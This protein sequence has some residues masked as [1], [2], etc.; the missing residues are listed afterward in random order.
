MKVVKGA[1]V[2]RKKPLTLLIGQCLAAGFT[3]GLHA[4]TIEV[5]AGA[6][7]DADDGVCSIV[8]AVYNANTN[9]QRFNSAGECEA[10]DTSV[11][12]INLAP[13]VFTLNTPIA[14]TNT[15]DRGLPEITQGLIING[16]GSTITRDN[17]GPDFGI[18]GFANSYGQLTLNSMTISNG[19][20]GSNYS[21]GGGIRIQTT[22]NYN[23]PT[24][25][26]TNSI[27]S[28]NVGRGAIYGNRAEINLTNSTIT[29]NSGNLPGI[30]AYGR[31]NATLTITNSTISGNT[32]SSNFG[33][34]V[35]TNGYLILNNTTV[36]PNNGRGL[37]LYI[38][39]YGG[40]SRT[41]TITGSRIIDNETQGSGGGIF[42][43][44][45]IEITDT[46]IAGNTA[47]YG[48]GIGSNRGGL[49]MSNSRVI[50]N[51]ANNGGGIHFY[52]NGGASNIVD[53]TI[54]GNTA[55]LAG[56]GIRTQSRDLCCD[57]TLGR[58]YVQNS[59]ITNNYAQTG[60]GIK[61]EGP[62]TVVNS[63]L[64]H[65]TATY[66]GG[67][68]YSKTPVS[69]YGGS[70]EA[71]ELDVA[72]STIT[73]NASF[74]RG[75]GVWLDL[76]T[77]SASIRNTIIANGIGNFD[78]ELEAGVLTQNLH[79]LIEDGTCSDGA[80][81]LVTGDPLLG[82]LAFNGSP[83]LSHR[84]LT[85]SLAIDAADSGTCEATDQRGA[86]RIPVVCDIGS[87]EITAPIRVDESAGAGV[88]A[89]D[90]NDGLCSLP[91]AMI[92]ANAD[93][94]ISTSDGEC[95]P[96]VVGAA[97]RIVLPS[98]VTFSLLAPDPT[99]IDNGLPRVTND[100][101]LE[102]NSATVQ[103]GSAD[104]RGGLP[105]FRLLENDGRIGI[106]NL[107]MSGGAGQYIGGAILNSGQLWLTDSTLSGNRALQFGGAI[108][109]QPA[110]I[111]TMAGSTLTQNYAGA[112]S[113]AV[114][115]YGTLSISNS[116]ISSNTAGYLTG[117][118]SSLTGPATLPASASITNST[119]GFNV[120]PYGTYARA[121]G[122]YAPLDLVN[123]LIADGDVGNGSDCVSTSPGLNTNNLVEDGTC[124]A[125]FSTNDPNLSLLAPLADNGGPTM[126]HDLVFAQNDAVDNGDAAACADQQY[127]QRGAPFDRSV[128]GDN[129]GGAVCDIGA[130]EFSDEL[131]P[132]AALVADD[133]VAAANAYDFMVMFSDDSQVN[134]ATVGT[135]D[136]TVTGPG[137]AI[138]ITG[139]VVDVAPDLTVTATYSLTPPGGVWDPS[140]NGTYTVELGTDEV[141]DIFGKPADA[142]LLG[143]FE[144]ALPIPEIDVQ[145]NGISIA[146]GDASPS[147][148][149]GT[150]FG[151]VAV[152]QSLA[153]TFTIRNT[154]TLD[155][156]L[157]GSPL[158]AVTGSDFVV[159]AQPGTS[160]IAPNGSTTFEITFTPTAEVPSSVAVLI[161]NDDADESLYDF[162]IS[163][164]GAPD[165]TAPMLEDATFD[166][167]NVLR[168][169]D[170]VGQL[171]VTDNENNIPGSG[172]YQITAG[173]TGGAF[174]VEDDGSI[175]VAN[176]MA[177]TSDFTLTVEVTDSGSLSD[178]ATVTINVAQ[179]LIFRDDFGS[180][181]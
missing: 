61:N 14:T 10:G 29:N 28:N 62:L 136:V 121:L 90:G 88:V 79:N 12:T 172:A 131:V 156:N 4:A 85:G 170:T 152:G 149:D 72:N 132:M 174:A 93:A 125:T 26:I 176:E 103:R 40:G 22:S 154:G 45:P 138:P 73:D 6:V 50:N 100:M 86:P 164:A 148:D 67:G 101:I 105:S 11:D 49:E 124:S 48:G 155:L 145:G 98:N 34:I 113:G 119:F 52:S 135:S 16:N 133:V 158:V 97:D 23:Q 71:A 76:T 69:T 35:S 175:T 58:I 20:L 77:G 96:G 157:T 59:A 55:T 19:D 5:D 168:T 129:S 13:S 178:T 116:T 169:G 84:P 83:T 130:V 150:D 112:I 27:I 47:N 25:T 1:N 163:G 141:Q 126:T 166:I 31:E 75:D 134:D 17:A 46:L 147:S 70:P 162:V 54:D 91:E 104:I 56:G 30:Y 179:I 36:G 81:D 161:E 87:I 180:G 128:D 24:L 107:T 78:C 137:G 43:N 57:Q 8:E 18:I 117:G 153:R 38:Y 89:V 39:G 122:S 181:K 99:D 33:S 111:I 3:G 32:A 151:G 63:T 114:D 108:A 21:S 95:E 74:R 68:L 102:G 60:G 173:N 7:A 127:D 65:N 115:N 94:Q 159:S 118:I 123:V 109:N 140:D 2:M 120:A 106:E 142:G 80:V 82:P 51:E 42:V 53:S 171:V 165:N 41:A 64:S 15:G 160:V 37:Y 146:D 9:S 66:Y 144:V 110:G 143:T 177:L 92:N 44:G 167:N 139:A